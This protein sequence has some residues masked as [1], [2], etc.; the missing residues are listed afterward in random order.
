LLIRG[1][2][3]LYYEKKIKEGNVFGEVDTIVGFAGFDGVG[4]YT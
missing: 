4:V 3:I 2:R 1:S